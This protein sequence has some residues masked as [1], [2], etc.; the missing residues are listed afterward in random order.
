MTVK[1]CVWCGQSNDN[2]EEKCEYCGNDKFSLGIFRNDG[3]V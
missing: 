3:E 1:F 2:E